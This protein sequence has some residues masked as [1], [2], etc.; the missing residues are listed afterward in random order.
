MGDLNLA[1]PIS[2]MDYL[3]L[4]A[5]ADWRHEYFN[6]EIISLP[7]GT[8]EHSRISTNC[9]AGLSRAL[10]G[11]DCDVYESSLMIH[12]AK[13][14][15]VLYP[16]LSIVCGPL[17]RD[18]KYPN[19]IQNPS[20]VLE[21]LSKGTTH[22]DKSGKFMRYRMIPSLL[23][24]VLVEQSE[25]SVYVGFKNQGGDW[26]FQDYFGLDAVV[27]LCPLGITLPMREIYRRTG[28]GE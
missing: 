3:K 16:D 9:I 22:Y 21:V 12:I 6:G 28:V 4:E 7:F 8:P 15:N 13:I 11:R 1:S 18:A 5:Q 20:L 19:L 24:Y 17:E 25:P 27:E 10:E 26:G 14:N 2:L 23:T